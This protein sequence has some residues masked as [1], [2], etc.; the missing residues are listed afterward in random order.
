V[1]PPS[2]VTLK[3]SPSRS[4][5]LVLTATSIRPSEETLMK[6]TSQPAA[7]ARTASGTRGWRR[8]AMENLPVLKHL[9]A[10]WRFP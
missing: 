8:V 9:A 5:P 2:T 1:V 3:P 4:E 7:N 10:P 6:V